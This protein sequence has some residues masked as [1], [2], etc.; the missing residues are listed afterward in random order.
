MTV[1]RFDLLN[2]TGL[3]VG[4]KAAECGSDGDV[5]RMVYALLDDNRR[6]VTA[7]AWLDDR[8]ILRVDRYRAR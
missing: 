7:E 4:V 1:H 8:L 2:V 5:R 3:L 6:A